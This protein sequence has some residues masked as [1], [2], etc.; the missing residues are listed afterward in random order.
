MKYQRTV[1]E[2]ERIYLLTM[3]HLGER[4]SRESWIRNV[5]YLIPLVGRY[6]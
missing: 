1:Q 2:N 3:V 4:G 5:L 6:P